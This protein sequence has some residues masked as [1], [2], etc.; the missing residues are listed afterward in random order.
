MNLNRQTARCQ[1]SNH[2]KPSSNKLLW[3]HVRP[4]GQ[5]SPLNFIAPR[6][7][8]TLAN[9]I[10][11]CVSFLE[12]GEAVSSTAGCCSSVIRCSSLLARSIW[13][14]LDVTIFR[15]PR[16][17]IFLT[18]SCL[19]VFGYVVPCVFIPVLAV[20]TLD[21]SPSTSAFLLSVWASSTIVGRITSGL[22]GDRLPFFRRPNTQ[23]YLYA[24]PNIFCGLCTAS[25]YVIHSQ[26]AFIFY[27]ILFGFLTGKVELFTVT[28]R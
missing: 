7:S 2:G 21:M 19:T 27:C 23:V 12:S 25:V 11:N 1:C 13:T 4:I 14:S 26:A 28:C 24:V 3:A 8:G 6:L 22:M 9:E 18:G 10:L 15:N 17:P 5:R 16:F 20:T